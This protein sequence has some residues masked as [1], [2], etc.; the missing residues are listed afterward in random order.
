MRVERHDRTLIFS[1][2]PERTAEGLRT[3]PRLAVEVRY[4]DVADGPD[5][6]RGLTLDNSVLPA[7]VNAVNRL[8]AAALILTDEEARRLIRE[9]KARVGEVTDRYTML[10]PTEEEAEG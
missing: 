3:L 9:G 10:E 2:L 5:G 1:D 8:H 4:C 7:I 6:S